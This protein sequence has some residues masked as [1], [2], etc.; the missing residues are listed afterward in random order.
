VEILYLGDLGWL[1][2]TA[3]GSVGIGV[4]APIKSIPNIVIEI[5]IGKFSFVIVELFADDA[6]PVGE[7]VL[8]V[9]DGEGLEV[10]ERSVEELGLLEPTGTAAITV[11]EVKIEVMEGSVGELGLL[12]P[13]V[14]E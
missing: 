7:V 4:D 11:G 3:E 9:L 10:M 5:I 8:V 1:I 13:T 14:G 2:A 12:K 6:I